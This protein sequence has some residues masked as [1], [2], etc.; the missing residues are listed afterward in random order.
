MATVERKAYEAPGRPESPV[1]LPRITA[2]PEA[3]QLIERLR[4]KHGRLAFF[5]SGGSCDGSVVMCLTRGELLETDDDLKLGEIGGTP[6]FVDRDQW[7]RCGEP[8]FV[9]D[10]APGEA[11]GFSLD[12]PEGVHFVGRAPE[13]PVPSSEPAGAFERRSA[14]RSYGS[15]ATPT[16]SS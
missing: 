16:V 9:I 6:F 2:T 5:Q 10:V 7:E 3:L 13:R 11:G 12:G 8:G 4:E 1:E 15:S 14:H